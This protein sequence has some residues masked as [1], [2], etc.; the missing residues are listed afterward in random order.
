MVNILIID[1]N[2][3]YAKKL[4]DY[5]NKSDKIKVLNIAINGEEAIKLLNTN[6]NIDIFLLDLKM[7]KYDGIKVLE[8]INEEKKKKYMNSCIIISG[9]FEYIQ[10]LRKNQ[11]IYTILQKN[12]DFEKIIEKI[13]ELVDQK[14]IENIEKEI[15]EK[16]K[17]E[18]LYIGYD[19]SHKGTMYLIKTLKYISQLQEKEIENLKKDVYPYISKMSNTSIHNVKCSIARATESMYYNCEHNRLQEYFKFQEVRKPN[20]KTIIQ[21]ILYKIA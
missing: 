20:I 1:D 5:I 2:I 7:P 4:M 14:Q 6:N 12:I 21:T 8:L 16:I 15:E 18:L 19:I 11:M 9:E 10:K 13:N 3:F 17:E